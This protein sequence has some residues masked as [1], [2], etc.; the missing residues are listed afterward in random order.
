MRTFAGTFHRNRHGD[1]VK[2]MTEGGRPCSRHAG[3]GHIAGADLEAALATLHEDDAVGMSLAPID[4]V[5]CSVKASDIAG[6]VF[7]DTVSGDAMTHDLLEMMKAS[8]DSM[9]PVDFEAMV[10]YTDSMFSTTTRYLSGDGVDSSKS[11][12]DETRLAVYGDYHDLDGFVG[13]VHRAVSGCEAPHDMVVYRTRFMSG[14]SGRSREEMACYEALN[15]GDGMMVRTNFNS[16]SI[17]CDNAAIGNG[18][19]GLPVEGRTQ[20]VIKV[21]KGTRGAYLEP[22][23]YHGDEHEFLIDKGYSY[24]VV[25]IYERG[26][27]DDGDWDY[28]PIIALEIVPGHHTSGVSA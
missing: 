4:H 21:P 2:C 7:P 23:S 18:L 11:M 14:A 6:E 17:D 24:K 19:S 15:D 13:A 5:R 26:T 27:L 20:Y 3:G 25:G 1:W 28:A 8:V 10:E 9:D 16:T 12:D 22:Y